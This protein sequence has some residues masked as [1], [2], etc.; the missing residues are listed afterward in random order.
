MSD[1]HKSKAPK[2]RAARKK[3]AKATTRNTAGPGYQFEDFVAARLLIKMLLGR[4]LPGIGV[5]S[6]TL[7][8]QT[9]PLNW[10][11]DDLLIVLNGAESA[12]QLA[13][14]CKSN[15]QVSGKGLP[16]DF[17]TRAWA[18]WQDATGPMNAESDTLALV[19][20]G[21]PNVFPALWSDIVQWCNAG[22]DETA[23]ARVRGSAKHA[24]VFD[25]IRNPA[26]GTEATDLETVALVKRLAIDPLDFQLEPSKDKEDTIE[27][28]RDLVASGARETAE[29]VWNEI[30]R[31]ASEARVVGGTISA[32]GLW[33]HL[34]RQFDLKARPDFDGSW[35]ALNAL[36]DEHKACIRTELPSGHVVPRERQRDALVAALESQS[37]V[38]VAGESGSGKSALVKQVLDGQSMHQ[39]WLGPEQ[40]V[41]ATSALERAKVS[42]AYPLETVL[43]ASPSASNVLVIDSAE[44]LSADALARLRSCLERFAPT[45]R[46]DADIPWRVVVIA[47]SQSADERVIALFNERTV[48]RVAV[49][50]LDENEVRR[51][52]QSTSDLRWL[53]NDAASVRALCNLKMLG[54]AMEA[55]VAASLTHAD[56][57]SPP[58]LVDRIWNYWTGGRA[59]PQ[60]LLMALARREADF[61]R[62]FPISELASGDASA[63]D[64]ASQHLPLR[65]NNRNRLI[66]EHDLAA[67]WSRFQW[68]KQVSGDREKWTSLAQNPLWS[69]ALR[70]LGQFLLRETEDGRCAWDVMLAAAENSNDTSTTNILLEALCLD[71][72]A[73]RFLDERAELLLANDGALLDRLL[74]RFLHA[75]TEPRFPSGGFKVDSGLG[76][77]LEA[78]LRNPIYGGWPA[79]AGFLY[80]RRSELAAI[81]SPTVSRVCEI[82]LTTTPPDLGDG[83]AT[84]FRKELAEIALANVRTVQVQKATGV[85]YLRDGWEPLYSAPLAAVGDV[86]EV[87]DWI[88]EEVRRRP[89]AAPIAE[90]IANI[91]KRKK[92][93]RAER[94][95]TD[96]AFA[97]QERDRRNR[98]SS[99]PH[100]FA[101]ARDLPP[102]PAGPSE[103]IDR[104]FRKAALGS[105]G[106]VPLMRSHPQL[107]AEA[108]LALLIESKPQKHLSDYS[109][110][111]RLGLEHDQVAYPTAFWKSPFF[112]F[113]QIA[114]DIALTTLIQ[115]VEFCTERWVAHRA[116]RGEVE[117]PHVSLQ[118]SG[119][120]KRFLGD[121][122]VFDWTQAE[123]LGSGQL[124]CALNALERWLT[125][126]LEAGRDVDGF[127]VRLLEE[128]TSVSVLGLLAN[129]VKFRP[130]LLESTL[131]PLLSEELM[132]WFDAARLRHGWFSAMAWYREGETVY[133]MA[134]E[135][136]GAA[137]RKQSLLDVAAALVRASPAASAFVQSAIASWPEYEHPKDAVESGMIRAAL[138][139]ANYRTQVDAASGEESHHLIYPEA[140]QRKIAAFE[141]ENAPRRTNLMLPYRLDEVLQQPGALD[142][143]SAEWLAAKLSEPEV[144]G[145]DSVSLRTAIA[146]TL[147]SRTGEWLRSR[148]H[149]EDQARATLLDTVARVSDN[150]DNIRRER[151][152][153]D[154]DD[155]KFAA[156]GVMHLWIT[157]G[158]TGEW[159]EP[160][161]RILTSGNRPAAV[162]IGALGYQNRDQLGPRWWRLLQIGLLWSALSMMSPDFGEDEPTVAARWV[163][164]LRWLRTGPLAGRAADAATIDPIKVW[165][166]QQRFE[167]ARWKRQAS[168]D[169]LRRPVEERSSS[170][171]QTDFLDG[172]FSWLVGDQEQAV[173]AFD[174]DLRAL[175]LRFW[176]YEWRWCEQARND[177]GEYH[178]PY[179]FGYHVLEKLAFVAATDPAED[180]SIAWRS[181]LQL[182][183]DA[184]VLIEHFLSAFL[185]HSAK[186][187]DL[188]ITRWRQMIAFALASDWTNGRQWF[189]GQRM[190]MRLLG[191]GFEA[192]LEALPSSAT[193]I[194]EMKPLYEQWAS[195]HVM[196]DEENIAA[197]SYFLSRDVG[198][199]LRLDGVKWIAKAL[200]DKDRAVRWDRDGSGNALVSVLEILLTK[201]A[202]DLTRDTEARTAV[203]N[204]A[205]E[206]ASKNVTAALAL[207]ERI[208][209][210]R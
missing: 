82:W 147:V 34:R 187:P 56:M 194:G 27:W 205:A 111:D 30:V 138:N 8:F 22:D 159:D 163:R 74:R 132:Y 40:V 99:I 103:R 210:L 17:V 57:A 87:T 7:H 77:Y 5:G 195:A 98:F 192:S 175:L 33:A 120:E 86:P 107:A 25:S 208:R 51:A 18:Q 79:V 119:R 45:T 176:E 37:F 59:D 68:L 153:I 97:K 127:L 73:G 58:S 72:E 67:D 24:T 124:H 23:I 126:E 199:P 42:L 21:Q 154:R 4:P 43:A 55:Q 157:A 65:Q 10:Q 123:D 131:R 50:Q 143:E 135:W 66:F 197:F 165:R 29:A 170:G 35:R 151:F 54:W 167:R 89:I 171:L 71:P 84:P 93:A 134:Q 13:L 106:L 118:L 100:V 169:R 102:W 110:I 178:L 46:D 185:L 196:A 121:G 105:V 32:E 189:Y 149:I 92:A 116:E 125:L 78:N 81:A 63:Y 94:L 172:L 117:P 203:V 173:Q 190:L 148:S 115:L 76:L 6:G 200:A 101:G 16:A 88:L 20:Q 12:R 160:L 164:R 136:A 41:A 53:A 166:L 177:R 155:L 47:Q 150:H 36:T 61:E 70:L 141:E 158:E 193:V 114:P 182:D 14:S 156:F 60:R 9:A 198:A 83:V 122:Q 174:P 142:P 180:A 188:F 186:N 69:T 204:V 181:V 90:R 191:F 144:D 104:D 3:A 19:T 26:G 146:A 28:C 112:Q 161:L 133:T 206:L 91:R 128:S 48:T 201:H 64:Q 2:K 130:L 108:L 44:K 49:G 95:R 85:L 140:L 39:V 109:V 113:F 145:E 1:T 152:G 62:S 31:L 129:V 162:V 15:R 96:P 80:R 137:Y 75:A 168:N 183:S 139:P 202:A 11:I 179:Q 209:G 52:L 38:L 207:Q 184:H